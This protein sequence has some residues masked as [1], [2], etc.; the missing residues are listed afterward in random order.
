MDPVFVSPMMGLQVPAS[1][2]ALVPW[3]LGLSSIACAYRI[4]AL[5]T[6]PYRR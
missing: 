3:V 6:E 4:S 5:L 2:P 1:M